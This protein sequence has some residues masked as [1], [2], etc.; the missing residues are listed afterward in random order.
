M[1]KGEKFPQ[2]LSFPISKTNV[3][4]YVDKRQK[5]GCFQ[6]GKLDSWN[7]KQVYK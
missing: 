3:N 4:Q 2:Q 7:Q 6:K 5:E 1:H